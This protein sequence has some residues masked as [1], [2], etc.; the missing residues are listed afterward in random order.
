MREAFLWRE[1]REVSSLGS[2]KIYGN[3]YEVDEDLLGKTVEL[4]FNPYDLRRILIY[5]EGVFRC[6]ARP[7]QMK[8]FT[9]KRVAER[10]ADSQNA[11]EKAMQA[12]VQEHKD[13][14]KK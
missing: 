1:K 11:L 14:I 4:R 5:C 6:E 8:S 7:Y 13:E 2:V 3:L 12:I 9:D 10:Q